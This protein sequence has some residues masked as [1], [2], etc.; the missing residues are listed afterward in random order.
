M[1]SFNYRIRKSNCGRQ[2]TQLGEYL[3]DKRPQW[4]GD[5]ATAFGIRLTRTE[6][7]TSAAT[8]KLRNLPKTTPQTTFEL[9]NIRTVCLIRT[10]NRSDL[11]NRRICWK[12]YV[13]SWGIIE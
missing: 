2:E 7:L 10:S 8:P 4:K 6:K 9:R 12:P 11:L 3:F 13:F 5:L 1:I